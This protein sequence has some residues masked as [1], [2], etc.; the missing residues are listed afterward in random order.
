MISKHFAR[1]EFA[2]RCGCGFDT[3]DIELI[4]VLEDVREK[5][6]TPVIITGPNRCTF[7]N[8]TIKGASGGSLHTYGKAAD[9]QVRGIQPMEIYQY[10]DYKYQNK[11]GLGLYDNR[12]HID[13]R[14][15]RARWNRAILQ[16]G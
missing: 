6:Q 3:V 5:F 16:D 2:C 4:T 9:I 7:Y 15:K 8:S 12:V 11:Y 10:L 1:S 13:V 14:S